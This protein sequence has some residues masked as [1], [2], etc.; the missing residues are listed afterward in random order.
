MQTAVSDPKLRAGSSGQLTESAV[1]PRTG[2]Q[3]AFVHRRGRERPNLSWRFKLTA[4]GA[5]SVLVAL[6]L[7]VQA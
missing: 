6:S 4:A 1:S 3:P 5:I 7:L 2:V